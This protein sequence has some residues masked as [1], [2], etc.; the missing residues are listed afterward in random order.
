M[1]EIGADTES[2][3]GV[4]DHGVLPTIDENGQM[5]KTP[6]SRRQ[7][8][9]SFD[10]ADAGI[11]TSIGRTR[12][13]SLLH[14]GVDI[15]HV[16]ASPLAQIFHPLNVGNENSVAD[17]ASNFGAWRGHIPIAQGQNRSDSMEDHVK[18]PRGTA[19]DLGEEGTGSASDAVRLQRLED[20]QKRIEELLLKVLGTR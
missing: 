14:R 3:L 16:F 6:G 4:D 10:N 15:A 5:K 7:S 18:S 20:G 2:D 19:E 9:I 8:M 12:T 11:R 1:F 13:Q 17:S